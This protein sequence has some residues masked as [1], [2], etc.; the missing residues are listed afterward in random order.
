MLTK[1]K[2][3]SPT[4]YHAKKNPRKCE[5]DS[6]SYKNHQIYTKRKPLFVILEVSNKGNIVEI[7]MPSL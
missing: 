6:V 3:K 4:G 1:S 2:P 7:L 5:N